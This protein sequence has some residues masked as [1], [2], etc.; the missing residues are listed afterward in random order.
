MTRHPTVPTLSNTLHYQHIHATLPRRNATARM[1]PPYVT[2]PRRNGTSPYRDVALLRRY[3]TVQYYADTVLIH[4][5]TAPYPHL[6]SRH[7]THTTTEL[8][9]ARTTCYFTIPTRHLATHLPVRRD[10]PQHQDFTVQYTYL[11][12][13]THHITITFTPRHSTN[14]GCGLFPRFWPWR[15]H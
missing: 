14:T 10:T 5:R 11:R 2:L 13:T 1:P 12:T 6:T 15:R 9:H 7:Y 3:H 4:H 8:H